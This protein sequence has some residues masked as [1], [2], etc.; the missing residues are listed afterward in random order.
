LAEDELI[1]VSSMRHLWTLIAAVVIAPLAWLLLA[2]GQDRSV[3]AFL[4]EQSSRAFDTGD[5]VQPVLSLAA[6][7]LLFGLLA[8]LRFSPLGAVLTGTLYSAS[9][10]TLLVDPDGLLNLFPSSV[11]LAGRNTDPTT[12]MRTG[13]TLVL[14]VLLLLGVVSVGRWR[15]WPARETAGTDRP[16]DDGTPLTL[17]TD[18]LLGEDRLDV[19]P[20]VRPSEPTWTPGSSWAGSGWPAEQPATTEPEPAT[21]YPTR[22]E[23]AANSR[24]PWPTNRA[25]E[26]HEASWADRQRRRPFA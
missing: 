2:L 19:T 23:S 25:N 16:G 24:S 14:G 17:P 10:L 18:R 3:Q 5:F 20:P 21:R 1:T 15:R 12:P 13:T 11:S 8:T 4:N 6:A 7:G 22:V 9:Y 26:I